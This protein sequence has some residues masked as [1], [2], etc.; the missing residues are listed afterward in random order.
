VQVFKGRMMFSVR[1][2]GHL[3]V[4]TSNSSHKGRL[5]LAFLDVAEERFQVVVATSLDGGKTWSKPLRVND[6]KTASNQ[7]NVGV[8]VN[9]HG[10]VG[11]VWNDRRDDPSDNCFRPYFTA[12][13]DG[14][15]SF[16]ANQ[17]VSDAAGCT[18]T[19]D[20]KPAPERFPNGGDTFGM[21][22]LPDGTFQIAWVNGKS[23]V[24][25]LYSSVIR[26]ESLPGSTKATFQKGRD[27]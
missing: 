25:Q 24:W 26:V 11:I 21:A 10:V 6:N 1:T 2:G 17:K 16:L 27:R 8:R 18:L 23:G 12:S 15:Q 7:S 5:Y 22:A 19:P 4:D 14:G 20:G 3:A 9:A 13:L